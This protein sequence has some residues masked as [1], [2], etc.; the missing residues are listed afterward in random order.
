MAIVSKTL[1]IADNA[2]MTNARSIAESA[3][4]NKFDI[5]GLNPETTY[6][7]EVDVVNDRGTGTSAQSNFTTEAQTGINYIYA[8]TMGD[9]GD[10]DMAKLIDTGI[11]LDNTLKVRWWGLGSSY[12]TNCLMGN[13]TSNGRQVTQMQGGGGWIHVIWL[14]SLAQAYTSF[15]NNTPID[16]TMGN[17][18][19]YNNLT[20]SYICGNAG[21]SSPSPNTGNCLIDIVSH[22]CSGAQVW[23]T[24]DGIETLLFD[25]VASLKEGVYGL[26]DNIT[27]QMFTNTNITI[28]GE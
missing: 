24:I 14:N 8:Q 13:I 16:F 1:R 11:A 19:L 23:K 4:P 28:T 25:G 22:K 26:W 3:T 10:N 15:P 6:Y 20:Q 18:Y 12:G 7:V 17:R 5:S 21:G 27:H 2:A 9:V